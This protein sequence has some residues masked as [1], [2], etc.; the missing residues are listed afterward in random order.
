VVNS[1]EKSP[2]SDAMCIEAEL[3]YRIELSDV[4]VNWLYKENS[5]IFVV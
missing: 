2:A 4:S 1:N 5:I 3:Y